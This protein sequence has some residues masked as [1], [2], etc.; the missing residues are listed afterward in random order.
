MGD[1]SCDATATA[2]ASKEGEDTGE[3]V[4]PSTLYSLM[5]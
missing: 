5:T 1:D 2:L 3:V 4:H